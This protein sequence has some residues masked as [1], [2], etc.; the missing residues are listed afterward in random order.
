VEAKSKTET[1]H[2]HV[3]SEID[4]TIYDG[5]FTTKKMTIGDMIEHGVLKTRLNGGF[6]YNPL[7]GAGVSMA[8]DM[9]S[10]MIAT[11]EV[12][13][14]DR[15]AWFKDLETI[16]KLEDIKVLESVH[17][18]VNSFEASFRGSITENDEGRGK[19]GSTS[20]E[21]DNEQSTDDSAS[22]SEERQ[23]SSV[24]PLVDKEVPTIAKVH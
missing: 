3:V 24:A 14:I 10:D 9:L 19:E 17:K 16:Q 5:R 6:S 13:L 8:T 21:G 2:V 22:Q 18:E 4:G 1:F 23:P 15:P 12:C 11:C 20:G 7:T